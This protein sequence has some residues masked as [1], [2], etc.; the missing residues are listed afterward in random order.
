MALSKGTA[1][2]IIGAVLCDAESRRR[3]GRV[4][5]VIK[6][7]T[8]SAGTLRN[9]GLRV[10]SFTEGKDSTDKEYADLTCDGIYKATSL[11]IDR[12]VSTIPEMKRT[13]CAESY[14]WR[15]MN[16]HVATGIE[17]IDGNQYVFDWH[18]TLDL[19]NPLL[20]ET[21]DNFKKDEKSIEYKFFS[22]FR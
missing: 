15:G 2:K 6:P 11:A 3:I 18:A 4:R 14:K 19:F 9:I 8:P 7:G 22:G 21:Y 5:G 10:K 20:F 1:A 16:Q 12:V 13:F 17:M